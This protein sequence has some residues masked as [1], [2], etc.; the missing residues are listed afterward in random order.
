MEGPAVMTKSLRLIS[1]IPFLMA[2]L[3]AHAQGAETKS[4]TQLLNPLSSIQASD[5]KS[6]SER[7]LFKPSRRKTMPDEKLATK[8]A[9]E[10]VTEPAFDLVLLGVTSGPDGSVARIA[11]GGA[12]QSLRKDENMGGWT[13]RK[14]D[15]SSV[16]LE[17]DDETKTLRIFNQDDPIPPKTGDE[18]DE[19]SAGPGIVFESADPSEDIQ[20]AP[21]VRV[22]DPK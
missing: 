4:E 19:V 13:L 6:F 22:I 9:S 11:S 10:E 17:K 2:S 8:A 3:V 20:N 5:L 14:I 16:T 12:R 21:S 15:A 18:E 1:M 7:P